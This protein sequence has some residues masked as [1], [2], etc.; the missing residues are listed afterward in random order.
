MKKGPKPLSHHSRVL[1]STIATAVYVELACQTNVW[2]PDKL[3]MH[4]FDYSD[5]PRNEKSNSVKNLLKGTYPN[6]QT[7]NTYKRL[8]DKAELDNI[9]V[10]KWFNFPL[11]SLFRDDNTNI[12][13]TIDGIIKDYLKSQAHKNYKNVP[14]T[15]NSS[16]KLQNKIMPLYMPEKEEDL[17]FDLIGSYRREFDLSPLELVTEK[18]D[19]NTLLILTA[20]TKDGLIKGL[21]KQTITLVKAVRKIFPEVIASTPHLYIRWYDLFFLYE[22][23]IYHSRKDNFMLYEYPA[24]K[25][26]K[27][28][29]KEI[30]F[31]ASNANNNG[32][33]I[34]ENKL[35]KKFESSMEFDIY[36]A[37]Q[38]FHE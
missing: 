5:N 24:S 22:S 32:I 35:F 34:Y 13:H 19:L 2:E 3:E 21:I 11:W 10:E 9:G 28:I 23:L 25:F 31:F 15:E 38:T 6:S 33:H 8:L 1:R 26:S 16:R 12:Q 7:L 20:L 29:F 18:P 4:L 27:G 36:K 37:G 17:L 14:P 30:I